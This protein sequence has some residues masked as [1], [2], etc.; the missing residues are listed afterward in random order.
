MKIPK[1]IHFTCKDKNNIDNKIWIQC[2]DKYKSMYPD[3]EICIHDNNDIYKLISDNYPEFLE[4]IKK[5]KTGAILADLFRYLI[6]YLEGGIY[7]DLDCEPI[8][9]IDE[10][11]NH[12]F[13]YTHQGNKY[14]IGDISTLLC[15]E[16]HQDY[17]KNINNNRRLHRDHIS[18]M[19][20]NFQVCQW[21]MVS[22]PK[23]DIFLNMF[24]SI[25][26]K[27][28]LILNIKKGHNYVKKIIHFTGP[29]GFTSV[30]MNN[31]R[32]KIKI[33]PSDFFCTGSCNG[34]V[35]LTQNSYIKHLF[36]GSW[37]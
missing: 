36:S 19:I 25:M 20:Y 37:L 18:T 32:D 16:F 7:S 6:L 30:L 1:K 35:P 11:L 14:K 12:D 3:Y 21:F 22:E 24:L 29:S 4:K 10:L 26:Y 2:L 15:Y 23:Q 13:V 8:K 5:I 27:L 17:I 33:L 31:S 34:K 9:K 28:D